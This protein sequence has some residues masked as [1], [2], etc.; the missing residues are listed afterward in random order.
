M[1]E[2]L[3]KQDK[4]F[5]DI[6]II[7]NTQRMTPPKVDEKGLENQKEGEDVGRESERPEE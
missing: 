3:I 4:I 7:R 5:G 1:K 6:K 2:V